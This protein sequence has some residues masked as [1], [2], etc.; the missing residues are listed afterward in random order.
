MAYVK[1]A[2]PQKSLRFRTR[3]ALA[4]AKKNQSWRK[5][6]PPVQK[7]GLAP[8]VP[9]KTSASAATR[10]PKPQAT[11]PNVAAKRPTSSAERACMNHFSAGLSEA[12][13]QPAMPQTGG[14]L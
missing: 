11:N 6:A 7:K 12:K 4:T 14:G 2:P 3:H 9:Q 1:N 5:K 13:S 10:Q 8:S